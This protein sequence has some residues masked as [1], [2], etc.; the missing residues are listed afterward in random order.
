MHLTK[1]QYKILGY[2]MHGPHSGYDIKKLL[3]KIANLYGSETNSQIY[4]SL[5]KLEKAGLI[6]MELDVGDGNRPKKIYHLTTQGRDALLNWLN[7]SEE[8]DFYRNNLLVKISLAEYMEPHRLQEQLQRFISTTQT[9]LDDIIC[10]KENME[11]Q[12]EQRTDCHFILLTLNHFIDVYHA[13]LSWAKSCL[14]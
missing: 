10:L 11:K 3:L 2:L 14:T 9:R 5:K 8:P 4:P 7:T 13:Q 12:R 1:N 6:S